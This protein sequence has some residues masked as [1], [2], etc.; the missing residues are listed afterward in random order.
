MIAAVEEIGVFEV[1]C[2][3]EAN[4]LNLTDMKPLSV[5][6]DGAEWIWNAAD[7]QF[8]G[9]T[10]VLDV[11]HAA[12]HLAT[13]GRAVFGEGPAFQTWFESARQQSL[14]DGDLGRATLWADRCPTRSPRSGWPPRRGRS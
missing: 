2:K 13:A 4:R 10:H 7:R 8:A 5:L 3:A 12:E 14:G 6:G 11:Y 9:A 1:R